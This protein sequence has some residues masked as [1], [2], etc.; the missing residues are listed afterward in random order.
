MLLI[1]TFKASVTYQS[2]QCSSRNTNIHPKGVNYL[3]ELTVHDFPNGNTASALGVESTPEDGKRNRHFIVAGECGGGH[4]AAA[5]GLD[6]NTRA[7]E[8][9]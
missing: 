2:V 1:Y 5:V 4:T 3:W 9:G 6:I 7:W 8:G